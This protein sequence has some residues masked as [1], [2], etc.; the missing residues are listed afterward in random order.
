[1]M[2]AVR[3]PSAY[4][5]ASFAAGQD[6]GTR[7]AASIARVCALELIDDSR[8]WNRRRHRLMADALVAYAEGLESA[9]DADE[10][11]APLSVRGGGAGGEPGG[12]SLPISR[13]SW[14]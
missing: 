3:D 4:D 14:D 8:W 5:G 2:R 7:V 13:V 10:R 6:C 9:A 11:C 1:M 12:A